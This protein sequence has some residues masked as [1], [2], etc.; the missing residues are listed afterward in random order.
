LACQTQVQTQ[1]AAQPLDFLGAPSRFLDRLAP[2]A[3]LVIETEI[4]PELFYQCHKRSIPVLLLSA[5]LSHRSHRRLSLVK[6]FISPILEKLSLT[7]TISQADYYRLIDLGVS[8]AK[9]AVIGSPKFDG[10]IDRAQKQLATLSSEYKLDL[11]DQN[12]WTKIPLPKPSSQ[13]FLIL[14]GSTHPG[15]EELILSAISDL[16]NPGA[17]LALAP[18]HLVRVPKILDLIKKRGLHPILFSESGSIRSNQ[19]SSVVVIDQ[20]GLLTSLYQQCDLALVGGSFFEG[21]GHNPLEPAA[22]GKPII[23]GPYMSSFKA[24][25]EDLE[26]LGAATAAPKGLLS[27]AI[28]NFLSNP[29]LA[30]MAGLSGLW[31]LSQRK[32]I[33]PI[34]AQAVLTFLSDPD[35]YSQTKALECLN[36]QTET[37]NS[38]FQNS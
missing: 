27:K 21:D 9:A 18:R 35:H 23:F 14:A 8:K 34:L 30:F 25:A 3:L 5:R 4:W 36:S 7:A 38:H 17:V 12:N 29:T 15:E 10:L 31:Y 28:Y 26:S 1:I 33:A 13:K 37:Y 2:R 24:E 11:S 32:T 22:A 6:G 16:P 19:D 20:I